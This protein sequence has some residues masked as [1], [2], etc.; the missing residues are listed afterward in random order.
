MTGQIN[1]MARQAK[2]EELRR[3]A[4]DARRG[5]RTRSSSRTRSAAA[6]AAAIAVLM[7]LTLAGAA[8]A[9]PASF[10]SSFAIDEA[11]SA[12]AVAAGDFNGD[13]LQ[14]LAAVSRLSSTQNA[15]STWL[16]TGNPSEPYR[17]AATDTAIR[18]G[19]WDIAVADFNDDGRDDAAFTGQFTSV[20]GSGRV[21]IARGTQDGL[22]I[23][24]SM[25]TG[26]RPER[27][28]SGD[29]DEDG[30][31]DLA[32]ANRGPGTAE[33]P[34]NHVTLLLNYAS[35]DFRAGN[36][37]VGCSPTSVAIGN[38]ADAPLRE[39]AA[40]CPGIVRVIARNADDEWVPV[41]DHGACPGDSAD[42]LA[43]H[44]A[45]GSPLDDLAFACGSDRFAALSANDGYA[46]IPGPTSASGQTQPWF[47]VLPGAGATT[48][49]HIQAG[50]MNND[51]AGDLL[52]SDTTGGRAI[53]AEGDG[54]GGFGPTSAGRMGDVVG[55][56]IAFATPVD[57]GVVAHD[58]N[59][60]GKLDLVAPGDRIAIRYNTTPVP[61][62]RTGASTVAGPHAADVAGRVNPTGMTAA[63]ATV[64]R[65][66][67][68]TTSAYGEST[69]DL[70]DGSQLTSGKY[71][72]VGT[73]L[74]GLAPGQTYHYRLVARNANGTTYG[75]DRTFRTADA[76]ADPQP[77]GGEE[78]GGATPP[79]S[80]P[81]ANTPPANTPP[82]NTP[83]AGTPPADGAPANRP[84][85]V[86]GIR[87]AGKILTFRL[88]EPAK[89]TV[90]IQKLR[91][92]A[93][94]TLRTL[95]RRGSAGRNTIR[96]GR[97]GRGHYRI[98][99]VAT[100][101]AGGRVATT[102]RIAVR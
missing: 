18:N 23:W 46:R 91:R 89:V 88:S 67:Y 15:L 26:D 28:A 54:A 99:L 73:H 10:D 58:M 71:V 31:I 74:D 79:T 20:Q 30:D 16:A 50:D 49:N 32:V 64:F 2:S 63:Q 80:T 66:E 68:G 75:Q 43:G 27:I 39:V 35:G 85:A 94:R 86:R 24:Y 17:L 76:P 29:I 61:G 40:T 69:P 47:A 87:L 13:G 55:R 59:D 65:F 90:R 8:H 41:E 25:D 22:D 34:S 57:G 48:L 60:D 19:P 93:Y 78:P 62:V 6:S 81:P 53:L 84:P 95:R 52:L 36:V 70:P 44:F 7:V 56:E 5:R 51:G 38:F 77:G 11:G 14:D 1:H 4:A 37:D 97:L 102:H 96:T 83:P 92:G 82:A 12:G 100:D 33:N 9:A 45:G 101:S 21:T 3:H 72:D 42:M 98:T